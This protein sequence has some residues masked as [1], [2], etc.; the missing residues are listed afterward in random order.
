[1]TVQE[2]AVQ[3]RSVCCYLR[4]TYYFEFAVTDWNLLRY[5]IFL[6]VAILRTVSTR[7]LWNTRRETQIQTK[8]DQP[9]WKNGQQQTPETRPQLQTSRKKR[10]WTPQE[11]MAMRRCRN[12]SNDLIHGGRWWWSL[13]K[14]QLDAPLYQIYFILEWHSTCFG[15]SFRPSSGVQDCTYSCQT[16]SAVCTVLNS[17]WWTERPS[18][19]CRVSFQNKI[20][21]IN[22]CI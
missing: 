5:E 9:P 13:Q 4:F 16:D 15:R 7:I 11:T 14:N 19:T 21:L 12:R 10:S 8:L 17:W 22:L 1:M 20:N 3:V 18:E 6:Y 2:A